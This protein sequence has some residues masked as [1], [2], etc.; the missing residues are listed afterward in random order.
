MFVSLGQPGT[1][2]SS[3]A[4][5]SSWTC[6][7]GMSFFFF[8][9]LGSEKV[10]RN[11]PKQ[12]IYEHITN[13][14]TSWLNCQSS[15]LKAY[16]VGF[17]CGETHPCGWQRLFTFGPANSK[18][19][20]TSW[21][22]S[23]RSKTGGSK[24][25]IFFSWSDLWSLFR[26]LNKAFLVGQI[27]SLAEKHHIASFGHLDQFSPRLIWGQRSSGAVPFT[28]MFAMWLGV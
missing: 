3:L 26:S 8:N 9:I 27:S 22:M 12:K 25:M 28:T 4:S 13:Q 2:G 7:A 10:K 14:T 16:H 1:P 5:F 23:V 21:N 18:H 17:K 20:F 24:D 6:A 15:S 11:S 19:V